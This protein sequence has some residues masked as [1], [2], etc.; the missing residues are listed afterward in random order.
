[1][2][3][4]IFFS[5]LWLAIMSPQEQRIALPGLVCVNLVAWLIVTLWDRNRKLPLFDVGVF[6]ALSTLVYTIY[7]LINYWAAGMQFGI[8]SDNRLFNY[9][10]SPVDLGAFHWRHVLYLLSLVVVYAACRGKSCF[11]TGNVRV[12][13]I[14]TRFVILT[15]FLL[16]G[17][18]FYLLFLTA[19]TSPKIMSYQSAQSYQENFQAYLA[20]PLILRQI[21]S[22]LVP[23]MFVFKLMLLFIVVQRWASRGWRFFL[24]VWIFLEVLSAICTKG[25][26]TELVLFSMVVALFY[27][28]FVKPISWKLLL[29]AGF[30]LFIF[31]NFLGFY[32][33]SENIWSTFGTLKTIGGGFWGANNEF[34]SL[35]G[36]AYDVMQRKATGMQIPRYLYF[37]DIVTILPPMQ[38][39]PFEKISAS[40]WYLKEIGLSGSG[41]GLMWG[42]ISQSIIGG[43]WA[44]LAIRGAFLGYILALIHRWCVRHS[45]SFF[46]TVFYA[47]LCLRIYYTFR[48]TTLAP[49]SDFVWVILPILFF[50]KIL[51][52]LA[53]LCCA[54]KERQ[55]LPLQQGCEGHENS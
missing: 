29:V 18:F 37:N 21:A 44:E 2:P 54:K 23:I 50:L 33:A 9:N 40:E 26:R 13:N 35:L 30:S 3:L 28:R 36:T 52:Y 27:H 39:I 41:A 22:K 6:C 38:M 45:S 20:L 34:Q 32:R 48:D 11:G 16:L 7:P 5:V 25:S 1:M 15:S 46:V 47:Y 24:F 55:A 10:V 51:P 17:L 49:I 12:P 8:L 19:G 42:V 53:N 43:D 4:A 14:D 31:F